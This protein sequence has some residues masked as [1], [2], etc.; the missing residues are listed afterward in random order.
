MRRAMLIRPRKPELVMGLVACSAMLVFGVVFFFMLRADNAVIGE[1]FMVFWTFILLTMT[2]FF[3]Y[4]LAHYK[5]PDKSAGMEVLSGAAESEPPAAGSEG[6]F[7]DK[8]RKLDRL[9]N[10]GLIKEEEFRTKRAEIMRE[11]W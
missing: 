1:V 4:Q 10:E 6:D 7:A 3:A 8:L 5:D 11:K 2:G 9:K